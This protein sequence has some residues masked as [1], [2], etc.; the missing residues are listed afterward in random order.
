MKTLQEYKAENRTYGTYKKHF[1]PFRIGFT[2]L[3]E[4][5]KFL[6][7]NFTPA[8][9][10]AF[11]IAREPGFVS[12]KKQQNLKD[13]GF[14]LFFRGFNSHS[15]DVFVYQDSS[16]KW[17]LSIGVANINKAGRGFEIKL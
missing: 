16:N 8:I 7:E 2:N 17:F 15:G 4:L 6:G 5:K 10:E 1:S 9:K 14:R 11:E 13:L 3:E 12:P